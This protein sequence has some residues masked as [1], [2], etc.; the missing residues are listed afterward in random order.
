MTESYYEILGLEKTATEKEISKQYKKLAAKWHPDKNLDNKEEAE[1]KFKSISEAYEVLSDP[2]KRQLYDKYGKEGLQQGHHMNPED[3]FKQMFGQFAE[4]Q[5][6]DVPDMKCEIEL[7]FEQMYNGCKI[8]KEIERASVCNVCFGS[9]TKDGIV[10]KCKKCDGNGYRIA[11]MGP[12]MMMKMGCD[13]CEGSGKN[14]DK[15]NECKK[16]HGMQFRKEFVEIEVTIPKGVYEDYPIVVKE[17][18]HAVLMEDIHKIGKKRSDVVFFVR[19]KPHTLFKRFIAKEKGKLDMSDL[20]IELNLSFGESIIGFN[21]QITHL[22]GKTLDISIQN[23]CRHDDVLVLREYGMPQMNSENKYGDLFVYIKVE[24]P[25]N[26]ELSE[27]DKLTLCSIFDVNIPETIKTSPK[28][29]SFDK[30]IKEFK[31]HYDSENIKQKYERRRNNGMPRGFQ[32]ESSGGC[33]QQ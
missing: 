17:E 28:F 14:G 24:H 6:I 33:A 18:G 1:E 25:E 7:T 4:E 2:E 31:N 29:I 15:K 21:K 23:P 27:K 16:C 20:A 3:I 19:E 9:G 12:G 8:T 10:S 32:S 26:L 13:A 5:E 11:M 22:N 30:Y